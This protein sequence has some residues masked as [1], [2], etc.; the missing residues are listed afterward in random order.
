MALTSL[1]PLA[2][3]QQPGSPVIVP[4]DSLTQP[5]F[6]EF[7]RAIHGP[8]RRIV[9]AWIMLSVCMVIAVA[10]LLGMAMIVQRVGFST[11]I[12]EL[13]VWGPL[14]LVCVI[15]GVLILQRYPGQWVGWV[16]C[17]AGTVW[18]TA[19]A[20]YLYGLVGFLYPEWDL[21]AIE[22]ALQVGCF[23]PFGL[24]LLIVELPLV[25]PTGRLAAPGWQVARVV[26]IAGAAAATWSIG[27]GSEY[28]A[29][30]MFGDIPNPI[31]MDGPITA[32]TDRFNGFD[33]IYLMALPA[34]LSMVLRLRQ[35][36]GV[37]RLQLRWIAWDAVIVFIGFTLHRGLH[38]SWFGGVLPEEWYWF[39]SVVWGLALNSISIVVAIAILR[40][41]LYDIDIVI[42]R[43]LLYGTLILLITVAYILLVNIADAGARSLRAGKP[44]T[45]VTSFFVA[46]AIALV[47]HPLY[48]GLRR[49]LNRWLFGGRDDPGDILARL[50]VRLESAIAP[51]DV[52]RDV[53]WAV[54][55]LL[56]LPHAA[57]ALGTGP[58]LTL[59]AEAGQA[60]HEQ[61]SVPMVYRHEQVGELRV[62]PRS[63]GEGFSQADRRVL[64][65][66]ARQAAVAAYALRISADLQLARERLVTTREEERR[67]LRRDLH[68]GLGAQLSALTIQAGTARRAVRRDPDAAERDLDLLQDELRSA[69]GDVRRLVHGLRPPALDEFGLVAAVRSRMLAFEGHYGIEETRLD[70]TGDEV[71]LPAAIEVAVYRIVEEA[72]TNASRHGRARHV[73]V[74][75][76]F[77]DVLQLTI[78]DDGVGL[79]ARYVPGVGVHSMRERAEEL[80]GTFA[81]GPGQPLGT[82][83]DVEIPLQAVEDA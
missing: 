59:A 42:H 82:R 31:Y 49:R 57:I 29:F 18:M 43:S 52:L 30:G 62:T 64:E 63:P 68:D 70:V 27:L 60:G 33:L 3:S 26:G 2:V 7:V 19:H 28:V 35:A 66:I 12:V 22:T 71:P 44:D 17:L 14:F 83:I 4:V 72:L 6:R 24:Y 13:F 69:I 80:G 58:A 5:T 39:Y 11:D 76:R 67:R 56:R 79:P 53:A 61:V 65:S 78:E 8:V 37:Q 73:A 36:E 32:L 55:D 51:S 40:L 41:R 16:L 9:P 15:T 38:T 23:Y 1:S 77:S 20:P 10:M 48:G 54:T 75:L 74:T 34:V 46:V 21:P 81:I 25:F 47:A 45:W 50:G